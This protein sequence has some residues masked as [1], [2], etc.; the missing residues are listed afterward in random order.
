MG[1]YAETTAGAGHIRNIAVGLL[2][3]DGYVLAEEY[4][5]IQGH[6]RFVRAIGGGIEFG[7][8]AA[9]AVVREFREEHGVEVT[10]AR[11]LAV[12]ENLFEMVGVPGHEVVHVFEV[13]CAELEALPQG[14]RVQALDT[15]AWATWYRLADLLAQDPPFYPAGVAALAAALDD[16]DGR[17]QSSA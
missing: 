2:V 4:P 17:V 11:L 9:D 15:E 12:T 3:R 1:A 10:V 8:R 5:P 14:A 16:R 7:E 6:H 13:S